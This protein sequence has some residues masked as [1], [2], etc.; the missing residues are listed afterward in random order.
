MATVNTLRDSLIDK[1]LTISNKEFLTTL[2]QLVD[3]S[4]VQK[5][6]VELSSS[7]I[8]MLK[9]SDRDLKEGKVI[10]HEE[11]MKKNLAWLKE[12]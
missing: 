5:G 12:Q 1:L 3:S 4:A 7:Q 8:E 6:H 2:N 9:L 10:A 11:V